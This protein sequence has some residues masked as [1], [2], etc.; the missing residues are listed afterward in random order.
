[1]GIIIII[2]ITVQNTAKRIEVYTVMF[3]EDIPRGVYLNSTK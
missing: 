2:I 3:R 1:M